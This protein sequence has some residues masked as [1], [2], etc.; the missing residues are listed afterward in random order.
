[1]EYREKFTL[2]SMPYE[3]GVRRFRLFDSPYAMQC[4]ETKQC[5]VIEEVYY[6]LYAGELEK[7]VERGWNFVGEDVCCY[8]RNSEGDIREDY[9]DGIHLVEKIV[10]SHVSKNNHLL[11]IL[12]HD[13]N[14]KTLLIHESALCFVSEKLIFNKSAKFFELLEKISK[15]K[16]LINWSVA[17]NALFVNLPLITRAMEL[18]VIKYS[19]AEPTYMAFTQKELGGEKKF[20]VK[21][22]E[23]NI[24]FTKKTDYKQLKLCVELFS[25][26][27]LKN[28]YLTDGRF[29]HYL[30][31]IMKPG[32]VHIGFYHEGLNT[33]NGVFGC[34]SVVEFMAIPSQVVSLDE[35]ISKY[36]KCDVSLMDIPSKI[37]IE[38][39]FDELDDDNWWSIPKRNNYIEDAFDG[40]ADAAWNI[41]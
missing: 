19:V 25:F 23:F 27:G 7:F 11:K 36:Y 18:A 3:F 24:H 39:D 5:V 26:F 1:M 30:D 37:D 2:E 29:G 40:Q 35:L 41:D 21:F 33:P 13:N 6:T 38:P 34:L 8:F 28:I 9:N 15:H 14:R 31:Y 32:M 20:D 17:V 10:F 12:Y 4:V 22:K 16:G